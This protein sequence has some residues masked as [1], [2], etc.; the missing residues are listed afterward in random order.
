MPTLYWDA[1]T[2]FQWDIPQQFNIAAACLNHPPNQEALIPYGTA[3]I[4]FGMLNDKSARL[5]NGLRAMGITRGDRVAVLL[6][7]S[8]ELAVSHLAIYRMGAVAVPL[9]SLFGPDALTYRLND[10]AAKVIITDP[11][12]QEMVADI[13]PAL[14]SLVQEHIVVTGEAVLPGLAGYENLLQG[15]HPT[16]EY[17]VT[18]SNDP[19][20][21]IYTS[22]TTGAP[23]GALHAHRVLLGHL[24]GVS[25]S[26]NL[27][28]QPHDRIW[29]P[30]DWAWI[31]GLFD[32]LFPAL[33]WGVPVVAHRMEKFDPE[34]AFHLLDTA[35]IRNTFLPP[36]ALKMMR[37]VKNPQDRFALHLRSVASGGEPLG[38]EMIQWGRSV[39]GLTINEFYGQT[40]CNMVL[41]NCDALEATAEGA[42]GLPVFGHTVAIVNEAG[43]PLANGQTGTIAVKSPDPVMFL[44]YWNNPAAT[45]AKMQKDWLM[46]GDLGYQDDAGY[47][48]FVA[49]ADD[50]ISSGG[51]RIGPGEIEECLLQHP[52][53]LMAAVVGKDDA[54][55][56]QIVTAFVVLKNPN[57]ASAA[58][59]DTLQQ[60]VK[61][62]LAYHEY[63]REITFVDTLPLTA[64]GK[65]RRNVLRQQFK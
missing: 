5:A 30:A 33:Y 63:P 26:H 24:P 37:Q 61:T 12:H 51:Y 10:S 45:A 35:S 58:L 25:L 44:E 60:W 49:R 43:V 39:L 42:A 29:T 8:V 32:V 64:S 20:V 18:Q 48:H 22:G 62:R 17:V 11:S 54:L 57:D 3:P 47:I 41:S 21:I 34:E 7:Q 38:Q 19:A 9:F 27:M 23:K 4:T 1:Y 55:R 50:L 65:V 13:A 40:E 2:H 59:K 52:S 28:P 15:S 6:S 46:T 16:H 36:T 56:G 31:G 53:V 14:P